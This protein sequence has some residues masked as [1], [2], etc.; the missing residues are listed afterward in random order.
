MSKGAVPTRMHRVSPAASS[1]EAAAASPAPAVSAKHSLVHPR[2][3]ASSKFWSDLKFC[4]N[5]GQGTTE[6]AQAF[7]KKCGAAHWV[8]AFEVTQIRGIQASSLLGGSGSG[9]LA[10][11][12][13]CV[14]QDVMEKLCEFKIEQAACPLAHNGFKKM[15][16][17]EKMEHRDVDDLGLPKGTSLKLK[18]FLESLRA[19]VH[20]GGAP[21]PAPA[22]ALAPPAPVQV[23]TN[24]V[25]MAV[26]LPMSK[27][28][29]SEEE[30]EEEEEEEKEEETEEEASKWE[31][32]KSDTGRWSA[33]EME[34]EDA[35]KRRF[36]AVHSASP[37][38]RQ[39]DRA[40]AIERERQRAR[41]REEEEIKDEEKEAEL[42]QAAVDGDMM[43]AETLLSPRRRRSSL[44]VMSATGLLST[45]QRGTAIW[46]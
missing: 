5:C 16:D 21:A 25:I 13:A 38:M 12:S 44:H 26:S 8:A 35:E 41:E 45:M 46:I 40:R 3:K 23:A 39:R 42:L 2:Y 31:C 22:P 7:C 14:E 36:M 28:S 24:V 33:W 10:A 20:T 29:F 15:R 11:T 27:A 43:K 9:G 19:P 18:A 17:L 37:A 30:E 4:R 6:G 34:E 32:H 1:T